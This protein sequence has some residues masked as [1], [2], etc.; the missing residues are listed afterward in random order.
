VIAFIQ[1]DALRSLPVG[2]TNQNDLLITYNTKAEN[3]TFN[4]GMITHTGN[5]EFPS[6]V[7]KFN[8]ESIKAKYW[9][10]TASSLDGTACLFYLGTDTLYLWNENAFLK[11]VSGSELKGFENLFL[12]QL[13]PDHFG[14]LWLCTSHGIIQLKIEKN[15][16]EQ[17]FTS[18]QQSIQRNSRML[19]KNGGAG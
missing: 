10:Q 3:N 19:Q 9:Y 8:T 15:R 17:F 2:F 14:N 5:C 6:N 7:N 13:F 16:F 1:K 12:Y 18:K 11:V 4:V